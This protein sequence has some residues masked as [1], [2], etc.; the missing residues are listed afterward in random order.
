[1]SLFRRFSV[2]IF[3]SWY[4]RG[5]QLLPLSFQFMACE[6]STADC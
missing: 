1:M 4:A 3:L 2:A 6:E 5:W